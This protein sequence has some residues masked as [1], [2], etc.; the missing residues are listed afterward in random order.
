MMRQSFVWPAILCA[1]G[2]ARWIGDGGH[3]G[4]SGGGGKSSHSDDV[5]EYYRVMMGGSFADRWP[6]PACPERRLNALLGIVRPKC[7]WP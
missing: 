7:A 5:L 2:D 1:H 4:P 3:D 6:L